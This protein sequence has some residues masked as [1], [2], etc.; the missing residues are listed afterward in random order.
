MRKVIVTNPP[1]PMFKV[2]DL[3]HYVTVWE[4]QEGTPSMV[5]MS[6]DTGWYYV[7]WT[8]P[9][10]IITKFNFSVYARDY[11]EE[12]YKLCEK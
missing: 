10:F 5:I 2:G 6:L 7:L 1:K 8:N 12:Y 3:L 9:T 4:F 11:I